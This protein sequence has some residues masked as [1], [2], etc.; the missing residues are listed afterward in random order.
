MPF[1][2]QLC[3]IQCKIAMYDN[4]PQGVVTYINLAKMFYP[5]LI[6]AFRKECQE[7]GLTIPEGLEKML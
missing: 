7:K 2:I 1:I 6:P 4:D 3:I 5:S